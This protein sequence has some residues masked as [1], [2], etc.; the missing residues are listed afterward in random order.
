MTTGLTVFDTTLQ[1]TNEWLKDVQARLAPC[2]RQQAYTATRAVMHMLRDRLPLAAVL[3]L[4]AQLPML[5][6]GFFLEGWRPAA[7]PT[8]I[9]R[10]DAFAE[11]VSEHLP[12]GFPR[13]STEIIHA[14]FRTLATRLDVGE[15]EKIKAQLPAP[16]RALWRSDDRAA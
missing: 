15:V 5:V 14:V 10:T 1:E 9:R 12:P 4:S 8:D 13:D 7:G 2:S 11:A 3:S 16:L 6:R